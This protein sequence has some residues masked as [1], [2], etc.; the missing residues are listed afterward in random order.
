MTPPQEVTLKG[1]TAFAE[2][3]LNSRSFERFIAMADRNGTT[4]DLQQNFSLA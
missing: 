2:K 3:T 1:I 4:I